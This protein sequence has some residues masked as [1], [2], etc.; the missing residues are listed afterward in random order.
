MIRIAVLMLAAVVWST[1]HLRPMPQPAAA[2]TDPVLIAT[3][4][5]ASCSST[6]D[7]ATAALLPALPGAIA[8]LG[9]NVYESGTASEFT[10][11]Y[12]PTWGARKADTHPAPGNHDYVTANATGY[13]GYFGAAAGNPS[14]GYYSYDIG[15]WHVIALNSNC[16]DIGGCGAGSAEETW[17]R[18]DL[19][20]H[21][22]ACTL[23]Y[24]HHPRFSSGASHGNQTFMQLI[25]QALYD[26]GADVVLSGHEHNYERF[27]PQDASGN[28]SL[29]GIREFVVGTGG[30]SHYGFGTPVANSE[31]RNSD[32]FGV[33]A[34]TLHPD[35]YDWRFAPESG[36]TFTDSGSDACH[37]TT[38]ALGGEDHDG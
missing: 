24:W 18:A 13:F 26:Y 32:T 30:K 14:Q 10:N 16:S 25:W 38:P 8:L 5:I 19:A 11:C 17:L 15:A 23:A 20:A 31:S 27:A 22:A 34:L 21:P 7:E 28:A 12:A 3:G 6:G 29:V 36:K 35:G 1:P 37:G 9:D 2:T 4:D 33:L